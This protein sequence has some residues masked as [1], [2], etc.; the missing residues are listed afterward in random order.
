MR[1]TLSRF[2]RTG[3]AVLTAGP[4]IAAAQSA[5]GNSAIGIPFERMTLPNGLNVILAPNHT[6]PMVTVD[7]WYHVGSKNEIPGHTGF[8]HMFEHVMFTGSKNVPYGLHDRMTEGVSGIANNGSTSQDRTNYYETV[9][10]NYLETVLWIEADRMGYLLDKL[11]E[12]K[13]IAQRDIVQNERRQSVDN[14]PYGRAGE[15]TTAALYPPENPYS[16]PIVGYLSELKA[17]TVDDVKNFFRLYYAPSNASLA[18][19]GDFEPAKVKALVQK[20]FGDLPRGNPIT[21]PKIVAPVLTSDKRLVYEDRVQIPQL[22]MRWPTVGVKSDD[23]YALSYLG[24][25]LT[26]SRTARLTKA[27]VYDQQAAASVFAGNAAREDGGDFNLQITPRA[28]KSLTDLEVA[29]DSVLAR[30]KREG[31]TKDE[32]EMLATRLDFSFV[33][34]LESNL[35]KAEQLNSGLV[36]HGDPGYFNTQRTKMK[37]VT[38]ADVKRVANKYLGNRVILSVVP[39]GKTDVASKPESSVKVTVSADGGHYIMGTK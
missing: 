26:G 2:A 9:P 14:Q 5:T 30:I 3:L 19:V 13:F 20:Y 11:D 37:T 22:Y 16:W 10:P 15:I 32:M 24:Q 23:S 21:R 34:G 33:A 1:M 8:A 12:A 27:L 28:G 4:A 31:P 18:I 36:M 38:A 25:I 39:M 7:V 17:A 6:T 29:T 35:G